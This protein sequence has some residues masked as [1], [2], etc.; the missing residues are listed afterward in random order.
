MGV[1]GSGG[2]RTFIFLSSFVVISR[3]RTLSS[4]TKILTPSGF[5]VR[6]VRRD[7]VVGVCIEKTPDGVV[8]PLASGPFDSS[9]TDAFSNVTVAVKR[10]PRPKPGDVSSTVPFMSSTSCRRTE[11]SA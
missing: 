2:R 10:D 6:P 7:A 8:V 5:F 3:I 1:R 11:E 9:L 4:A